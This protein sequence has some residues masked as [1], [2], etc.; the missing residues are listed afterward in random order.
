[1]EFI[2]INASYTNIANINIIR[3]RPNGTTTNIVYAKRITIKAA[4]IS[5][6]EF[7]NA[8][9]NYIS[10]FNYAQIYN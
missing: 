10:I 1:M 9:A 4:W 7:T 8:L 2:A 6:R 5:G 3:G